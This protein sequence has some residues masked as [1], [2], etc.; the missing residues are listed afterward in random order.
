MESSHIFHYYNS[1]SYCGRDKLTGSWKL[2]ADVIIG[3]LKNVQYNLNIVFLEV[4]NRNTFKELTI[5]DAKEGIL[6]YNPYPTLF[7]CVDSIDDKNNHERLGIP[8]TFRFLDDSI[9]C[10]YI[11]ISSNNWSEILDNKIERI[12]SNYKNG[13][14]D[15][16]ISLE[17]IELH[18]R[19]VKESMLRDMDGHGAHI[20]P[21]L[22][23]SETKMESLREEKINQN[24]NFFQE[25]IKWRILLV[26]DYANTALKGRNEKTNNLS[27]KEKIIKLCIGQLKLPGN[28]TIGDFLIDTAISIEEAEEKMQK[29]GYDIIL[30]DYLLGDS[31]KKHR[32]E[33]SYEL[34]ENIA[35]PQNLDKDKKKIY[36]EIRKNRPTGKFYFMYISAFSTAVRERLQEQGLGY[37]NEFWHLGGGACPTNTPELFKY[38]FTLLLI[39]QLKQ[40]SES[41]KDEKQRIFTLT[42]LVSRI[43]VENDLNTTRVNAD[44]YFNAVLLLRKKYTDLQEF[45]DKK[46][47]KDALKVND[48]SENECKNMCISIGDCNTVCKCT[49]LIYTLFPDLR[50][51]NPAFWEHLMH[52]V[53]LTAYGTIRQW[54]EM[55]EEYLFIKS[56]FKNAECDVKDKKVKL[57]DCIEKHIINLKNNSF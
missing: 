4:I 2:F 34:L 48:L 35:N 51:Y 28:I 33:Y 26:D 38:N 56:E 41:V 43:Y 23:H 24:I 17:Y 12:K 5:F 49:P 21:F 46:K 36:D 14:Y 45:C 42:E 50:N 53:Y 40:L 22:F 7:F 31:I 29:I 20:S 9:W 10:N 11:C 16:N 3:R 27:T 18:G 30:L 15:K 55:W 25:K 37:S 8:R 32:R 57:T 1:N 52:L 44:K 13:L 6:E 19:L 54:P 39:R 47:C